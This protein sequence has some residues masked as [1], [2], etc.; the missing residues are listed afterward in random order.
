MQQYSASRGR[1]IGI[2]CVLGLGALALAGCTA[3]S[4]AAAAGTPAAPVRVATAEVRSMPIELRTIGSVE[5]FNT[6]TVKSQVGGILSKV[7][8]TEG[9]AVKAGQLLFE[10]DKRPFEQAARQAEASLARDRA[11][12]KQTEATLAKDQAQERYYATQARRYA[13]LAREGVFSKEQTDQAQTEAAARLEAVRADQA[14]LESIRATLTADQAAVERAKLDLAYCEIRSP[15]DGR[16]GSLLVKQ[17]NLVKA[18]DVELV[19][20]RQIQPVYVAF[21]L[22][23]KNVSNIRA[24][25]A[26]GQLRVQVAEQGSGATPV[27]GTLAFIENTVDESTGTL[28]MKAKFANAA[29]QF[30]PG[31]ILDVALR[32]SEQAG[33]IVVPAKCLQTGQSGNFVYVMKGDSTVEM[34]EVRVGARSGDVVALESGVTAGDRVVTEGQLRLSS[35]S[36]VRLLS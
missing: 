25:M 22:A 20:I 1:T 34:R 28:R 12:L 31:Q 14:T 10:I 15:I 8:F 18:T 17:G 32:L 19:T 27:E 30:W 9:D 23:E 5:A 26:A 21:A 36:K 13:E 35:G 29:A 24:K 16:T 3:K 6:I 11:L 33:A 4:E 7:H 2:W